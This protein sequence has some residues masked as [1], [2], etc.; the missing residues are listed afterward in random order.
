MRF[1][2]ESPKALPY[3]VERCYFDA[4]QGRLKLACERLNSYDQ[5]FPDQAAIIYAQG[6]LRR[7]YLGQ[8]L[9]ARDLFERSYKLALPAGAADHV[10]WLSASNVTM[11]SP[12][13]EEFR[14]WAAVTVSAPS[15]PGVDKPDYSDFFRNF[16]SSGAPYWGCLVSYAEVLEK[17]G[18]FGSCAATFEV[19]LKAADNSMGEREV[20]ARRR[21][22]QWI[23]EL[24]KQHQQQR[25]SGG[26][27]F[28]DDERLALHE[29]LAELERALTCDPYDAELWNLKAAWYVLLGRHDSALSAARRAIEAREPYAKAHINAGSSL[30]GLGKET[31]ARQ[32]FDV[33]VAQAQAADDGASDQQAR[34][35]LRSLSAEPTSSWTSVKGQLHAFLEA[36]SNNSRAEME[37]LHSPGF[38]LEQVV[39][40]SVSFSRKIRGPQGSGSVPLLAELLSDFTPETVWCVLRKARKAAPE[41]ADSWLAA[42]LFLILHCDGPERRDA[43]R[44]LALCMVEA[45][46]LEEIRSLYRRSVLA[47][48]AAWGEQCPLD[49][50]A[51]AELGRIQTALPAFIAVQDPIRSDEREQA[52]NGP[53]GS[54]AGPIPGR[55]PNTEEVVKQRSQRGSLRRLLGWIKGSP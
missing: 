33:A 5:Q 43:V 48:T 54:L 50:I 32:E 21:R 10:G 47:T 17:S 20:H 26:E 37:R 22:A 6:L 35:L 15:P 30:L 25:E 38:R 39:S 28:P 19:A 3:L 34:D 12:N 27:H 31:E 24:D 11:L 23:R 18:D 46:E 42:S 4:E 8:G 45:L 51:R 55:N 2:S 41:F 52:F 13:E 16:E 44:L 9:A 7:K 49:E 29:A 40:H 1:Y 36:S 53:V 14:R